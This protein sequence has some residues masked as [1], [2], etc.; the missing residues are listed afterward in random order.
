MSS[1]WVPGAT[2][3]RLSTASSCPPKRIAQRATLVPS[4]Q[5]PLDRPDMGEEAQA[6]AWLT[7]WLDKHSWARPAGQL[8]AKQRVGGLQGALGAPIPRRDSP[9]LLPPASVRLRRQKTSTLRGSVQ[10]H[11]ASVELAVSGQPG[12]GWD[13]VAPSHQACCVNQVTGGCAQPGPCTATEC[14]LAG[15]SML[16]P[17]ERKNMRDRE[18]RKLPLNTCWPGLQGSLGRPVAL[19]VGSR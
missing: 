8:V 17:E 13:E 2:Q 5:K 9:S 12:R 19:S 16:E 15:R 3:G 7:E 10:S 1:R 6:G 4:C 14:L 18:W 11:P